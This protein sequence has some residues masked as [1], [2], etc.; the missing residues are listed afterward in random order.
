M[1]KGDKKTR[2]GKIS[3]GSHGVRRPK[4]KK[5]PIVVKK[6]IKVASKEVAE[7]KKAEAKKEV[8]V[9]KKSMVHK[10]VK[11]ERKELVPDEAAI[12]KLDEPKKETK[13]KDAPVKKEAPVKME[14]EAEKAPAEKKP[15]AKKKVAKKAAP[16]KEAPK[17]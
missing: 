14:K 13:E 5:N 9:E 16:K 2:K 3:S 4:K 8:D 11:E 6:D 12:V 15:A 17:D 1:G 10:V 7:V